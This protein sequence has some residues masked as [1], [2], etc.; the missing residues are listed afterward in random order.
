MER[1]VGYE[2]VGAG[3]AGGA[4]GAGLVAER[5]GGRTPA[6]PRTVRS[7]L[8]RGGAAVAAVGLGAALL[9]ACSSTP[10]ATSTASR[11]TGNAPWMMQR[12]MTSNGSPTGSGS[13]GAPGS[14]SGTSGTSA[15]ASETVKL[16]IK[17][18]TTPEGSEPAYVGSG[19][20]GAKVLFTAKVGEKVTV[21]V[22]NHDAMPHTFTSPDLGVDADIAPGSTTTFTFTAS[23]AGTFTWYCSV[24]CGDWV[25]SHAGY[26]KGSVTVTA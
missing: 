8:R 25:M 21:S 9:A 26:M 24:P 1:A 23:S 6:R 19:G 12:M 13:S 3:R 4:G 16:Q 10:S 17:D 22:A 18:V 2:E 11:V 14:S 7:L 15:G 5:R 20:A